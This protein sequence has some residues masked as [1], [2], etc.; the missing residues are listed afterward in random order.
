MKLHSR[1]LQQYCV[2]LNLI[3]L[4]TIVLIF[5]LN[6]SP[7][8]GIAA[9]LIWSPPIIAFIK[10]PLTISLIFNVVLYTFTLFVYFL[11]KEWKHYWSTCLIATHW[12]F[13]SLR[14]QSHIQPSNSAWHFSCNALP[15]MCCRS[16]TYHPHCH[17]ALLGWFSFHAMIASASR[18]PSTTSFV[19]NFSRSQTLNSIQKMMLIC[20]L[21]L[22]KCIKPT[23]WHKGNT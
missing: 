23:A 19:R 3:T 22:L 10:S 7:K 18:C 5:L 17:T 8:M 21:H 9:V 4:R 13:S 2:E 1:K 6:W 14:R 15:F 12:D 11:L 20:Y 16:G